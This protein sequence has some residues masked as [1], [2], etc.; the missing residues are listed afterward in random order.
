MT[1]LKAQT[2]AKFHMYCFY[3]TDDLMKH[4]VPPGLSEGGVMY[5]PTPSV[6]VFKPGGTEQ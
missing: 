6:G 4:T 3:F 5:A 1:E 2:K